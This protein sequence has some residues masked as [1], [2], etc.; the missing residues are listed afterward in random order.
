[1]PTTTEEVV[2]THR[3]ENLLQEQK[4]QIGNLHSRISA[5]KD[6]MALLKRDLTLFKQGVTGDLARIVERVNKGR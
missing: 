3:L 4:H 6:E 2:D 1:M 5:I